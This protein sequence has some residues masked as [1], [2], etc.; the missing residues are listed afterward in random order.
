MNDVTKISI[1]AR[2]LFLILLIMKFFVN[3]SSIVELS[4]RNHRGS[5]LTLVTEAIL[6]N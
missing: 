1:V 3:N 6:S 2:N 4:V 5:N